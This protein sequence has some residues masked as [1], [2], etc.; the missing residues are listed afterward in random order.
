ML[1]STT[2]VRDRAIRGASTSANSSMINGRPRLSELRKSFNF[3]SEGNKMLALI[4]ELFPI[5]RSITGDGLRQTLCRLGELI[6]L[7]THE[8]ATGTTVFDWTI[9][10]EW[11]IQ[12][13]YVKDRD[14]R[15]V[16]DFR[17]NNL[18]VVNYSASVKVPIARGAPSPPP[19]A[20]GAPGLD[21][22]SHHLLRGLLGLLLIATATRKPC[23]RRI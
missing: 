4:R 15:R 6:P 3:Q 7:E 22:L 12:D 2:P 9:P 23:R 5:C 16:V 8:V 20:R 14:G 19:F 18:H 10:K 1:F 13:A 21:S 11:N 17:A